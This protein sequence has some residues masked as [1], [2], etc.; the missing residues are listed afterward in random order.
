[1]KYDGWF[2]SWVYIWLMYLL[3]IL[4]VSSCIVLIVVIMMNVEV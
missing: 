3:S 1:M 4:S 2:C